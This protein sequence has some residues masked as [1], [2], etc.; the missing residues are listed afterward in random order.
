[1]RAVTDAADDDDDDDDNARRH[2]TT[3]WATYR[4][5]IRLKY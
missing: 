4:Q 5:L 2:S 3:T 1:M